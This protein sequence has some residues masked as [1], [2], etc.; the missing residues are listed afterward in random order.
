MTNAEVQ[1]IH[2]PRYLTD[3]EKAYVVDVI[4]LSEDHIN[5]CN[6]EFFH[7]FRQRLRDVLDSLISTLKITPLEIDGLKQEIARCFRLAQIETGEP[8]GL[9]CAQ[10]FM[11]NVMQ[12]T[13]DSSHSAGSLKDVTNGLRAMEELLNAT[14]PK[15]ASLTIVL[16][17]KFP[18]YEEAFDLR[19]RFASTFVKDLLLKDPTIHSTKDLLFGKGADND[20]LSEWKDE[21]VQYLPPYYQD[22][23]A[24]F[25]LPCGLPFLESKEVLQLVL[26]ASTMYIRDI[27]CDDVVEALEKSNTN[28]CIRSPVIN[29][30]YIIHVYARL[31]KAVSLVNEWRKK[32]GDATSEQ[33]NSKSTSEIEVSESTNE[34]SIT[35]SNSSTKGK[36]VN[37][38]LIKSNDKIVAAKR[39][40]RK[41]LV[42]E[43][44]D[45][46][47]V[48]TYMTN[49]VI[50]SLSK[51]KISGVNGIT[52]AYPTTLNVWSVVETMTRISKPHLWLLKLNETVMTLSGL[53]AVHL[54]RLMVVCGIDVLEIEDVDDDFRK[55][56][57][58][59]DI[60]RAVKEN[61]LDMSFDECNSPPSHTSVEQRIFMLLHYN[62]SYNLYPLVKKVVVRDSNQWKF[63]FDGREDSEGNLLSTPHSSV[64]LVQVHR[65]RL[66]EVNFGIDDVRRMIGELEDFKVLDKFNNFTIDDEYIAIEWLKKEEEAPVI[67]QQKKATI[68]TPKHVVDHLLS[69][70]SQDEE[71]FRDEQETR[72]NAILSMLIDEKNEDVKKSLTQE[73]S[74]I[75]V[76]R[77]YT[78]I[79]NASVRVHLETDGSNLAQILVRD[80]I[81]PYFTW[82]NNVFEILKE[83]GIE[84]SV[85]FLIN[86]FRKTIQRNGGNIDPRHPV[87]LSNIMCSM[88][89]VNGNTW[90][91]A[92]AAGFTTL[93]QAGLERP[94]DVLRRFAGFGAYDKVENVLDSMMLGK[95][96]QMGCN[97]VKLLAQES[98]MP[99]VKEDVEEVEFIEEIPRD[100]SDFLC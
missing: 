41:L 45:H 63:I 69:L 6:K 8:V 44:P 52:A 17:N 5:S 99:L 29:G 14:P 92:K 4:P 22:Y 96:I 1:D 80:D 10:A 24:I 58:A 33:S 35:K 13:L 20:I 56:N 48:I 73:A 97:V 94:T 70:D 67:K 28:V 51:L 39:R 25:P 54:K 81:D 3:D 62:I 42:N 89:S 46:R 32:T 49:V 83:L 50:P 21:Y 76:S 15:K 2:R 47:I 31:D 23:L 55:E 82:S 30:T 100:L 86:T 36:V 34:K 79:K 38:S 66:V 95:P 88:G 91:S 65:D 77:P 16:K 40:K 12:A 93:Q 68:V 18:T 64:R 90:T 53:S 60:T 9:R 87:L 74:S 57:I 43:I 37:K 72:R 59:V 78:D 11:A 7:V 27:S 84:A 85:N 61:G 98:E 71:K 75:I 26:S 19:W